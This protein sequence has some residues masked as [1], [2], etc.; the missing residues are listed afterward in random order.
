MIKS[1]KGFTL[2]ELLIVIAIITI[3]STMALPSYQDRVIRTQVAQAIAVAEIAKKDV[4]DYYRTKGSLPR[5]NAQAGLPEANRIIGNY[6]RSVKVIDGSVNITFGNRI[7]RNAA[8]RILTLRPAVVKDAP[9]VPIAWVCGY[10]T[11]PQGMT[12]MA[13]NNTTIAA[14]Q[15]PIDCRY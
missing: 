7:N 2:I 4:E 14:R 13:K 15:V 10:A 5:N 11:V 3:L 9:V 8:D 6:V 12:V 1:S